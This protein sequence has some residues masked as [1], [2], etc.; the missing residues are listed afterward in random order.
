MSGLVF[1][2]GDNNEAVANPDNPVDGTETA[3]VGD[4]S[5][6]TKTGDAGVA[7]LAVLALASAA[8][9]VLMRKKNR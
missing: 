6:P 4:G 1:V 3:P 9:V 8:A 5:A 2:N 7:G